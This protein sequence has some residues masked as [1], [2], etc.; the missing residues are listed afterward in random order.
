MPTTTF[1]GRRPAYIE[2]YA[3]TVAAVN[4]FQDLQRTIADE[5]AAAQYLDGLIAQERQVLT[6]LR[7]VFRTPP[8]N[9]AAAQSIITQQ[10][11]LEDARRRSDASRLAATAGAARV[12]PATVQ[13]ILEP[14]RRGDKSMGIDTA[15][16]ALRGS[17]TVQADKILTQLEAVA[18]QYNLAAEDLQ[19]LRAFAR[20]NARPMPSG[21]APEGEFREEE[22]AFAEA[23]ESA[24]FAGESGIRGGYEGLEIV[25]LRGLT[26]EA[27]RE[28]AAIEED[29]AQAERL[30]RRAKALEESAFATADDALNAAFAVIRATG[31]PSAIE[32]EYA[33]TIYEEARERQAYRN[34]Q[35]AE[36]EQEVLDSRQRLARL[37]QQRRDAPGSQ[38]TD[39]RQEGI[40]REL[41]ARGYDLDR[42]EG[43]YLRYQKSPYYDLMIDA[44]NKLRSVLADDVALEPVNRAQRMAQTLVMQYDRTGTE[45]DIERLRRQLSKALDG[46][47]L[48]DALAYALAYK[49]SE[50]L[51][52]SEPTQRELQ[53]QKTA[54]ER[55]QRE[56]QRQQSEAAALEAE[57]ARRDVEAL[58]TEQAISVRERREQV[59]PTVARSARSIYTRLR[60]MGISPEA[61]RQSALKELESQR[62]ERPGQAP[63]V[64]MGTEFAEEV[65]R[66][67]STVPEVELAPSLPEV[68]LAP[69][70]PT[71]TADPTNPAYEYEPT[72]EGFRVFF[73]GREVAQ[74]RRGTRAARSI[75]SVL[76]GGAP[77]PRLQPR[78]EPEPEPEPEPTTPP[79]LT[80][81]SDEELER[82]IAALQQG[83]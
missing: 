74:P 48:Q 73:Q 56:R 4:R 10:Y 31:D 13:R 65:A 78:P 61:A 15:R 30:E 42:N 8:A 79:P 29:E 45:Y 70:V 66:R 64:L 83:R 67:P 52:L 22:Q 19:E 62:I 26:S 37:E 25:N 11:Q 12:D 23:L 54:D 77:L 7:E 27:L 46:S 69:S 55:S 17:T 6:N 60:A 20:Q 50:R 82:A 38:Y 43:R 1:T 80:A 53:R 36:F 33:R 47:E 76:S 28:R 5:Q 41:R 40:R 71:R 44:D 72:E 32:D 34:D 58:E 2:Q 39:P 81:M 59:D 49:E 16:E 14:L 51:S 68:E 35:R 24:Y 3:R 57:R 75:E 9:A 18:G 63:R 21:R